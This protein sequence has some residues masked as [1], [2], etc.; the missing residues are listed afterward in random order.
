[1]TE[2]HKIK[3]KGI[4]KSEEHRAKLSKASKAWW[5]NK[6]AIQDKPNSFFDDNGN[7]N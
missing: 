4:K 6:K 3:L 2:E 5:A 7:I 1:L